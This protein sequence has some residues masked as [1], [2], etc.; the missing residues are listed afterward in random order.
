M[1]SLL[2]QPATVLLDSASYPSHGTMAPVLLWTPLLLSLMAA[3]NFL[4]GAPRLDIEYGRAGDV[5]LRMDA[6][7]PE[8]K[9]PF[10][11]VV[12]V[13]GGAW[14]TGDR[15]QNMAPLFV[16]LTKAGFACFTISYRFATDPLLFGAAIEDVRAA[17]RYLKDHADE[18]H[19]DAKR[20]A[21]LGESA[22]AQLAS[23]AVLGD[24][25]LPVRA[26]VAFYSP[27]D[28]ASLARTSRQVP[29]SLRQVFSGGGLGELLL[30]RLREL[31]PVNHVNGKMPPFLLLHGTADTVVP[32][33]QS[34][35]MCEKVRSTGGSCELY[36]V[37]GG[38]HS[39][40][41]WERSKA[42]SAYR[43]HMIDWLSTRLAAQKPYHS[44]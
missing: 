16:P 4:W 43:S 27:S 30:W 22:G 32:Y 1:V 29:E 36:T 17:V 33:E 38:G 25:K 2:R 15:F 40:R 14:V 24:S 11:A 34:V 10:P 12:L 26:L 3:P 39:L 20:I 28:L 35:E 18:F 42:Q 31:S 7:I 8:G 37:Q 23:M 19:V 6:H 9:G 5:S 44:E 21:L 41:G 13:H